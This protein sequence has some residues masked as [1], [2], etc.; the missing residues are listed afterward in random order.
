[1]QDSRQR[2][3]EGHKAEE[4]RANLER[5]EERRQLEERLGD[6]IFSLCT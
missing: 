2:R 4:T 6:E 3:E 1:V 5:W